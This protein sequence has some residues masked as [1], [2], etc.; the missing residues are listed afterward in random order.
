M[1]LPGVGQKTANAILDDRRANGPFESVQDLTRVRGIGVKTILE[2]EP[3]C[4]SRSAPQSP[5]LAKKHPR[6][7]G[8]ATTGT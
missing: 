5:A 1:L 8:L 7:A 6:H 3:Y 2:I 4:W